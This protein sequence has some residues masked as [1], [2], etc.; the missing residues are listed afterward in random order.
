[1]ELFRRPL[2]EATFPPLTLHAQW[3]DRQTP[4]LALLSFSVFAG[5]Q[6]ILSSI[7]PTPTIAIFFQVSFSSCRSRTSAAK[8]G[9][10]CVKKG[11]KREKGI[12]FFFFFGLGWKIDT[13]TQWA[14]LDSPRKG[15]KKY[16][17]LPPFHEFSG[18]LFAQ[19]IMK[20]R[21]YLQYERLEKNE[22]SLLSPACFIEFK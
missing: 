11:R 9:T 6:G 3:Q 15:W 10:E 4:S 19:L 13:L 16:H 12:F 5:E 8:K 7:S 1:M 14:S 18:K 2:N 22:K 17:V 21:P 20:W